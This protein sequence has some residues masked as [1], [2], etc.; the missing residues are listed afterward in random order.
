[1]RIE[2][3]KV[4]LFMSRVGEVMPEKPEVGNYAEAMRRG[5]FIDEELSEYRRAVENGDLVGIADAIGDMLYVVIGAAIHH[6]MELQPIFE[7]IHRSNMTKTIDDTGFKRCVKGLTYEEPRLAEV[8]IIQTT[9][10]Q[11]AP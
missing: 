5:D 7:E 1:M 8:L 11:E 4:E 10:L 6:G 2:Q 3:E 9:G